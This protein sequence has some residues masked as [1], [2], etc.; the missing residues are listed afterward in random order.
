MDMHKFQALPENALGQ[1]EV[2]DPHE[3]AAFLRELSRRETPLA[4]VGNG[5][6]HEFL[7]TVLG[8]DEAA[9]QFFMAC[10]PDVEASGDLFTQ[11][12]ATF[13]LRDKDAYIQFVAGSA[14]RAL[15][16][17][18]DAYRLALPAELL[19]LQRR[20][21]Y[22][23]ATPRENPPHCQL[24]LPDA[25]GLDSMA[26]DISVC[27]VGLTYQADTPTVTLGQI[28]HGCRLIVPD[29]AEFIISLRVR[30]QVRLVLPDG[31]HVWRIG[32][33]FV[34][35]TVAVE[36]ELQRY[37]TKIGRNGLARDER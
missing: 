2:S 27:G 20:G 31:R 28:L 17:G 12:G 29:V 15:H 13:S 7:A 23:A 37:I 5:D 24:H 30:N 32:C 9:G 18:R 10:P 33:E 35:A 22:R 16:D 25:E 34:D 11:E 6:K 3:V 21:V 19:R 4:G 14:H 8:V 36:R 1:V 26:L